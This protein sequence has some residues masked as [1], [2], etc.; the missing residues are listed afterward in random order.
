MA[1]IKI[2]DLPKDMKVSKENMRKIMGGGTYTSPI[3]VRGISSLSV[4]TK[5]QPASVF[6]DGEHGDGKAFDS[7]LIDPGIISDDGYHGDGLM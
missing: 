5:Y 1:R 7:K 2:K 4:S 3:D 6:D